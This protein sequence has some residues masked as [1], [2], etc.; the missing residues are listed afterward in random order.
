[1]QDITFGQ[2]RGGVFNIPPL[3]TLGASDLLYNWTM[4]LTPEGNWYRKSSVPI[5][6]TA[7]IDKGLADYTLRQI[8]DGNGERTAQ[9]DGWLK[10]DDGKPFYYGVPVNVC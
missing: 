2:F 5:P 6:G 3:L 8:I 7:G 4:Q 1:M 9:F 10:Y